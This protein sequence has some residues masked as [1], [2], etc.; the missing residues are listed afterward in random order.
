MAHARQVLVVLFVVMVMLDA[1]P[2]LGGKMVTYYLDDNRGSYEVVIDPDIPTRI[3]FENP[4]V[5]AYAPPLASYKS[6]QRGHGPGHQATA[7][8]QESSS[9]HDASYS[10]AESQDRAQSTYGQEQDRG[11]RYSVLRRQGSESRRR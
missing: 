10:L 7:E 4:I 11:L 5:D 9:R 3:E 1:A 2:A 6:H 8:N